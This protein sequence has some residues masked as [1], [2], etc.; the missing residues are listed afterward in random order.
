[1]NWTAWTL[2][3]VVLLF[4]GLAYL[5]VGIQV[6]LSHY[7]QN[8]HHKVM[9]LPVTVA[10]VVFIT[11]TGLSLYRTDWLITLNLWLL[12][13]AV[14]IGLIGFYRHFKGVGVRVGGYELRNFLMGPPVI[15]PIVFAAVGGLGLITIYYMI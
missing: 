2:D 4:V 14:I 13:F 11:A 3:R 6:T 12:W 15:L 8:F 7:R 10:P 9:Y 5:L 1:M